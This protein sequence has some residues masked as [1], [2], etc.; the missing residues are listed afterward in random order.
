MYVY[1]VG[2]SLSVH[3]EVCGVCFILQLYI[4]SSVVECILRSYRSLVLCNAIT[5]SLVYLVNT[6]ILK[7]F[8]TD[9]FY[10][11]VKSNWEGDC[12]IFLKSLFQRL[13]ILTV[14]KK[15]KN[16]AIYLEYMNGFRIS[17]S[18]SRRCQYIYI[19]QY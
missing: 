17:H 1:I 13:A 10:L 9:F 19:Y 12:I 16:H 2:L 7:L 6:V 8:F 4:C 15:K 3:V 14:E 11:F 5:R 18:V